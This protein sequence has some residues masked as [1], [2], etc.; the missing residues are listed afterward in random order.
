[1]TLLFINIFIYLMYY[2]FMYMRYIFRFFLL[3][4]LIS[5]NQ[6]FADLPDV[7]QIK[8]LINSGKVA[9]AY[10]I[11][12]PEE[13]NFSGNPEVDYLFAIVA[14]E[15]GNVEKS[16][17][18]FDRILSIDPKFA[19]A[20]MD[21]ARAYF[22][23]GSYNL[24]R[25]ELEIIQ[26]E[27]PPE[28]VKQAINNYLTAIDERTK[29]KVNTL[30]A[31]SELTYGF[32]TNV[33][34]ATSQSSIAIPALDNLLVTL[35]SSNVAID[36]PYLTASTGAE[37]IHYVKPGIRLLVG[38]DLR[39]K[40]AFDSSPYSSGSIDGHLGIRLGEEQDVVTLIAQQGR[41]YLG[42]IANRDSKSIT[43]QWA[44]VINPQ[45]Q[46][47]L[48]A[49][50]NWIRYVQDTAKV[51]NMNMFVGG[52]GWLHAFDRDAKFVMSPTLMIGRESDQG[53]R[54]NGN[55]NLYGTRLA[56]QY[57]LKDNLSLFSSVGFQYGEYK[58]ENSTFLV[59]R[60][61]HLYDAAAGVQWQLN[62]AWSVRPQ[63]NYIK[64]NSNIAIYKYDRKDVSITVRWDYR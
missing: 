33:N 15:S 45:N 61:D 55:K 10:A 23:L 8:T 50:H 36:S 35:D 4:P 62:N 54:P 48:F 25:Q 11:L 27:N 29:P 41:F 20:R 30:T 47:I 57:L 60:H 63:V 22:A 14:I 16:I 21:L 5:A 39:K 19:G 26:K 64:N 42:G 6:V 56:G 52:G 9:E 38:I 7:N 18:I 43:G 49:S 2:I 3:I 24:A 53:N 37:I 13:E 40:N 17:S 59:K 31:Y 12:A 34:A 28:L 44:H 58:M 51:E 46:A 32:D 1:M